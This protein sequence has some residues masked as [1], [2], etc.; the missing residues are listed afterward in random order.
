[1][2][3]SAGRGEDPGGPE[4]LHRQGRQRA[5]PRNGGAPPTQSNRRKVRK[6]LFSSLK[7]NNSLYKFA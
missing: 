6:N 2:Q 3:A 4:G 1:M 5:H 7:S